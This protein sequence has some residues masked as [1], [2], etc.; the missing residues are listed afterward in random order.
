[1]ARVRPLEASSELAAFLR[2][3]AG[4][5]AR[6]LEDD[7][8]PRAIFLGASDTLLKLYRQ[9]M[10]SET[11]GPILEAELSDFLA[12]QGV[13][14]TEHASIIAHL[15]REL[16]SLDGADRLEEMQAQLTDL[17]ELRRKAAGAGA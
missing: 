13:P 3:I 7:R 12:R 10:V 4:L 1:V 5:I 16:A 9:N 8:C 17:D 11:L 2:G 6:S 15:D 14:D